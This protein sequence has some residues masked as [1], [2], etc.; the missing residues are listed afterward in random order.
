MQKTA[1]FCILALLVAV[2]SGCRTDKSPPPLW[3]ADILSDQAADGDIAYDP[4]LKNYTITQAPPTLY[5]GIDDL[6]PNLPEYRAFLDFP[7]DGSTGGDVVPS[8]A[9]IVSATLE[10]FVDHLGFEAVV[11]TL[12][13]LVIYP[14]SGLRVQDFDSTPL[15]WQQVN[16]YSSDYKSFVAID[17]TD[18][19]RE[20]QQRGLSDFQVR[21]LLDPAADSGWVG[22]EDKP[23]VALTAPLLNVVYSY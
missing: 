2:A 22:I 1:F 6:Y 8:R 4:V 14:V 17:V 21:F 20:A 10:V 19:M 5:F 23:T 16:F 9:K 18:L 11:P 15:L 7:L 13:D 12:L 3:E